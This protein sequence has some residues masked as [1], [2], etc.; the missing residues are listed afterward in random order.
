V[1]VIKAAP[2]QRYK[3]AKEKQKLNKYFGI[4]ESLWLIP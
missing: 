4:A 3:G 2:L 1:G